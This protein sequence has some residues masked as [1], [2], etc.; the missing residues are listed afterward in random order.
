[1]LSFLSA[2]RPGFG[3]ASAHAAATAT[4]AWIEWG[5]VYILCENEW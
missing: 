2:A 1:M 3:H 4:A 5:K